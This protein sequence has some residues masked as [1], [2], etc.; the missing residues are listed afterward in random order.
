MKTNIK[1]STLFTFAISGVMLL[2][3]CQQE[4]AVSNSAPNG[5]DVLVTSYDRIDFSAVPSTAEGNGGEVAL[6]SG[7]LYAQITIKDYGTMTVKLYNDAAPVGV[8][9]FI[10]QAASGYYD[11]KVMHRIISDFMIQGGSAN[12]DG[13][14]SADEAKFDVEY[15][16]EMRHFYGALCY[17]NAA[18]VNGNQFYIVN[19]KNA[20]DC[21]VSSVEANKEY[22]LQGIE[23]LKAY[24]EAAASDDEREYYES[25]VAYYESAV[26]SMEKTI[27]AYGDLTDAMKEKYA[28]VGGTSFLDGGYTVFGQMVDGFDVLDSVSAVEV[29]D[30]G[31]GKASSPVETVTIESVKIYI[32]A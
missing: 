30:N 8:K 6:N 24:A 17:A 1:S 21:D 4:G 26:A 25:Y 12:G 29:T 15:C 20:D 31:S 28:E 22:Y 7:D 16:K 23:Q 5:D 2:S 11:G 27:A 32:K 10:E 13:L 18:G 9:N 14:S 19:N 3:G